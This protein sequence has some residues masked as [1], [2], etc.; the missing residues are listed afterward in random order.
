MYDYYNTVSDWRSGVRY[1]VNTTAGR[2]VVYTTAGRFVVY[3]TAG[4]DEEP[5]C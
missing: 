2:F 1:V 3:I 5:K 4:R